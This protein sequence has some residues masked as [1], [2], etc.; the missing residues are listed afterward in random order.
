MIWTISLTF[1]GSKSPTKE[2][3]SNTHMHRTVL[4][5]D[6]GSEDLRLLLA[7]RDVAR[8]SLCREKEL[9]AGHDG[10]ACPCPSVRAGTSV[11][12]P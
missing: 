12:D 8:L 2:Q 3:D 10:Q 7:E 4:E 6:I 9:L 5:H 11:C 1:G